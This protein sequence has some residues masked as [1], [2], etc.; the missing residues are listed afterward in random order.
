MT[1]GQPIQ[2][3]V[4]T[5]GVQRVLDAMP[6]VAYFWFRDYLGRSF[7]QHRVRWLASK[8]TRF[9]RAAKSG[10]GIRVGEVNSQSGAL[11]QNEVRYT[12]APAERKM[13]T[14]AAAQA[15][16]KELRAE[17]ATGNLVLP[18][19]EFGTDIVSRRRGMFIPVRTLPG[20]FKAW[21]K[22]NP[23]KRLII[24]PSKKGSED[25]LVY[26]V[27][28]T[29]G[30]GRPRKDGTSPGAR[31]RLRLR[32]IVKRKVD[33]KPT[34]HFY[35]SWDG[36]AGERDRLFAQVATKMVRDMERADPRDL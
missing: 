5:E 19:H 8:G 18:V 27:Q 33:M 20:G 30:R 15:A 21:R 4:R 11:Q 13:A 25:R 35:S 7:V 24:V 31:T 9:G 16:M 12:V 17:A 29:R 26:E 28:R 1:T 6:K 14:R 10:R 34:L 32:W 23:S 2:L 22:K 36:M 3:L